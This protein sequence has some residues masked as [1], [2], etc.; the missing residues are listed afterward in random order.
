MHPK[1]RDILQLSKVIYPKSIGKLNNYEIHKENCAS[2]ITTFC[3]V[4]STG[5]IFGYPLPIFILLIVFI[6]EL[7]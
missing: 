1:R 2:A 5:V 6:I 4:R 7:N 3:L